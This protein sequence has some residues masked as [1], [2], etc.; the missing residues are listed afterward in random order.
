MPTAT[1]Q[2]PSDSAALTTRAASPRLA[3]LVDEQHIART[4]AAAV[5]DDA[6]G[7]ADQQRWDGRERDQHVA[8]RHDPPTRARRQ[9]AGG[10]AQQQLAE[11]RAPEATGDDAEGE[12]E[13]R[14]RRDERPKEPREADEDHQQAGPRRGAAPPREQAGAHKAP[15]DNGPEHRPHARI[16]EVLAA[17][18]EQHVADSAEQGRRRD[19]ERPTRRHDVILTART[20]RG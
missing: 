10:E 16:G 14:I 12:H 11:D 6:V 18:N 9:P 13:W 19:G 5:G 20:A 4:A 7:V 17:E 2:R 1:T 3:L 15:T 8:G